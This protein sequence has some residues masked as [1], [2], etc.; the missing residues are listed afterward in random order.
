MHLYPIFGFYTK[1]AT[2]SKTNFFLFKKLIIQT[3][4]KNTPLPQTMA[5]LQNY[6]LVTLP[7]TINLRFIKTIRTTVPTLQYLYI[8]PPERFLKSNLYMYRFLKNF[9][10][11]QNAQ[12]TP[13]QLYSTL[14]KI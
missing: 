3:S 5:I 6:T 2:L 1:T 10:K 12:I 8:H 7:F 4:L 13:H 11:S 9:N 14:L